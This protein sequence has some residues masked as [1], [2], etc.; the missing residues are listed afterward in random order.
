MTIQKT[1]IIANI[2]NTEPTDGSGH[3][4]TGSGSGGGLK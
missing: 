1:W 2:D 3:G 4:S